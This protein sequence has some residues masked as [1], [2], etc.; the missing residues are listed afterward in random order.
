LQLGGQKTEQQNSRL[1]TDRHTDR[2]RHIACI[3]IT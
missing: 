2:H 3:V 1:V